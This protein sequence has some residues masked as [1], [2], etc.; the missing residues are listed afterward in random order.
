LCAYFAQQNRFGKGGEPWIGDIN[1]L[2]AKKIQSSS[3]RSEIRG[4]QSPKSKRL[5]KSVTAA[6]SKKLAWH[7][8]LNLGRMLASGADYQRMNA[9]RSSAAQ[10]ETALAL[11]TKQTL[12]FLLGKL[13]SLSSV[14]HLSLNAIALEAHSL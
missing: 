9:E 4:L 8:L 14:D 2:V 13:A 7:G 10:H 1:Q 6:L 5:K 3:S 12:N 11:L